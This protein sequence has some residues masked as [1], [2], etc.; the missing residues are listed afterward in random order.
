MPEFSM[1]VTQDTIF[2]ELKRGCVKAILRGVKTPLNVNQNVS[3]LYKLF[4]SVFDFSSIFILFFLLFLVNK[5]LLVTPTSTSSEK[6]SAAC[7][8]PPNI[9][10]AKHTATDRNLTEFDLNISLQF[11]CFNGYEVQGTTEATCVHRNGSTNWSGPNMR[12]NRELK[13]LRILELY[14]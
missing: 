14:S 10:H 12:C 8:L 5:F 9:P 1:N 3:L 11:H 2:P 13:S 6:S 7:G 4:F